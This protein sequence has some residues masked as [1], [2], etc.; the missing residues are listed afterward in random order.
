MHGRAEVTSK[1]PGGGHC[2]IRPWQVCCWCAKCHHRHQWWSTHRLRPVNYHHNE[3]LPRLMTHLIIFR[4]VF[5]EI[6]IFNYYYYCVLLF[7]F[8]SHHLSPTESPS[9]PPLP[10]PPPLTPCPTPDLDSRTHSKVATI[11]EHDPL[12]HS[13][14]WHVWNTTKTLLWGASI[15]DKLSDILDSGT[16]TLLPNINCRQFH[17]TALHHTSLLCLLLSNC[18]P[19]YK[20]RWWGRRR[21]RWPRRAR[22]LASLESI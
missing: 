4:A 22:Q 5:I 2:S 16:P 17:S 12:I 18:Q 20:R 13:F 14:Y 7:Y 8:M 10:P 21:R 9:S 1:Q 19:G 15:V 3:Y 6:S 11:I